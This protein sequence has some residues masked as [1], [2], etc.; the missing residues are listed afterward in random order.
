MVDL[1]RPP[2]KE[3][4][5]KIAWYLNAPLKL[6]VISGIIL[7]SLIIGVWIYIFLRNYVIFE[8]AIVSGFLIFLFLAIVL[9]ILLNKYRLVERLAD[10]WYQKK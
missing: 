8:I 5:E 6:F 9:V 10:D 7:L 4:I 2:D 3:K 1:G